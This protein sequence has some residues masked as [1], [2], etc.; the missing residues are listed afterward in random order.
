MTTQ[1][2]DDL[3]ARIAAVRRFSRFYTRE[4]GLLR[5]G[6]VGAGYSLTEGRVLYELAHRDKVTASELAAALDMDHGYLS[7]I[8]RRFGDD[9]L[10][11]KVRAPNDARQSLITITAKGRKAFAPLNKGSHDQVAEWLGRLSE[12]E[13]ARV[14]GAM[15]TV[16]S[17]LSHKDTRPDPILLRPHRPGD[18]GWVTSAHGAIYANEY[19]WDIT[20][21]A[22][23]A[24][25]VAEFIENFDAK[26][27]CCWIAEMDGVPVGSSFVVNKGDGIAKLR[28]VI[29][30]AKARGLGVGKR[31]V[32]ECMRFAKSAGY[33][34][35]TLWTQDN[36]TAARG[37]YQRAGFK[38]VGSEANHSFGVDLV[39]ETWEREL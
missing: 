34:S 5:E 6:L 15:A 26:R 9:G 10:L 38:L 35:M 36:L 22:M 20:F 11:K 32:E 1:T 2:T 25:I 37:I 8:L 23:V 13:Q 14:V 19:G 27:E 39:S 28:L 4:L 12:A 3:E 7:R 33:K 29:V 17:L 30:D 24:K 31:L 16:E 21:E 18:M